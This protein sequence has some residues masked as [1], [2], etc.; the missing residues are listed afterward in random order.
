MAVS[1]FSQLRGGCQGA[2]PHP[3]ELEASVDLGFS[4]LVGGPLLPSCCLHNSFWI[5]Q[6]WSL[7]ESR[8]RKT[9]VVLG[10]QHFQEIL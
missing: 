6:D 8:A 4:R 5:S 10:R 9:Q 1:E 3:S 7:E 2:A